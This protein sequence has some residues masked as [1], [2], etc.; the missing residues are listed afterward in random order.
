MRAQK[1][2]DPLTRVGLGVVALAAAVLSFA[3]LTQLGCR[4]GLD[5]ELAPLL[6]LG[7]DAAAVV[8]TRAWMR[9]ER[10]HPARRYAQCVALTAVVL[11]VAGNA[12]EH[13][14]DTYQLA[15]PW[16]VLTSASA[17]PPLLLAATAHLAATVTSAAPAPD[18]PLAAGPADPQATAPTE[19][20]EPVDAEPTDF[21][22]S[23]IR[24]DQPP[25][26]MAVPAGRDVSDLVPAAQQVAE[27]LG[28]RLTRDRLVAGLRE[29]GLTVGGERKAAI[30]A[31]VRDE[32]KRSAA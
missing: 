21:A 4:A 17:V 24:P 15:T 18:D 8:A 9:L 31:F 14:M 2:L 5:A 28:Q 10:R 29:R 6:P 19:I 20:D 1:S 25:E 11:S 3:A 13:A 16:W 27:Q 32:R 22:A 26:L 12:G 30:Y 23:G 7:I